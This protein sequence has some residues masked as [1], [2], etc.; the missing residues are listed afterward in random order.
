LIIN[1]NGLIEFLRIGHFILYVIRFS[2]LTKQLSFVSEKV[3]YR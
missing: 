1:S 3:N 2:L